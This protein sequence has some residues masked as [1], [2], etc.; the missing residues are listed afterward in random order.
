MNKGHVGTAM[1]GKV[2]KTHPTIKKYKK[3]ES[4]VK[5]APRSGGQNVIRSRKG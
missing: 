1:G 5:F 4:T 3:Y 2:Y